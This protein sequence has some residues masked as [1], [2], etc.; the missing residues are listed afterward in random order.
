MRCENIDMEHFGGIEDRRSH[1]KA[2]ILRQEQDDCHSY[3]PESSLD[4][5]MEV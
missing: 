2:F 4:W 1:Y 3:E 5:M